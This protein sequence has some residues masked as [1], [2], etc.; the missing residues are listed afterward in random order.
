M[1]SCSTLASQ[2]HGLDTK[3]SNAYS[4]FPQD[5]NVV[6]AKLNRMYLQQFCKLELRESVLGCDSR[7]LLA[8]SESFGTVD[9]SWGSESLGVACCHVGASCISGSLC[10]EGFNFVR[11]PHQ[12][13]V[14]GHTCTG[15][16]TSGHDNTLVL[17]CS[18]SWLKQVDPS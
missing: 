3:I 12:P 11:N 5:R 6:E 13:R 18:V 7:I 1:S 14:G 15:F 2:Q 10:A 16:T 4:V 8:L 17:A 9:I